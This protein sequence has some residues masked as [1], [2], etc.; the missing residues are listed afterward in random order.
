MTIDETFGRVANGYRIFRPDYPGALFD[1]LARVAPAREAA[2]DVGCGSGQAT[3]PLAERFD[4][5]FA[6]D[7]SAEQVARAP[8]HPRV[9]YA[10]ARAEASGLPDRSVDLVTAAQAAHW[11][12]H[13]AFHAE[14]RRVG[15]PGAAIGLFGYGLMYVTPEIDAIVA[16]LYFDIVGRYW[17]AERGH[18]DTR[19]RSLPF[20][21]A[22]IE[23]PAF[24]ISAEWN[25]EQ[26][27][28]YLR[29]WSAVV[30][31]R[32]AEGDDP[33]SRVAGRLAAAWGE[34]TRT[35]RWPVLLRLGRI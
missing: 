34:G 3:L 24:E 1:L 10:A 4:T 15:R 25:I 27:L 9:R 8:Q 5:V 32:D 26:V 22:E 7:A 14:V 30:R 16:Q 21:F 17:P 19:Y 33:V 11:F 20:P 18:V 23:A 2:W 35:V 28:G 31:F 12:D 29:T 6:T 13:D